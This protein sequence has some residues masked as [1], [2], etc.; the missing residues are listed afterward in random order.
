MEDIIDII[1]TETTNTIEITAQP[2]D[3]IIDVNIIDNRE[4]IVLNVTPT[5]VEININSL[6]GN[7]GVNWGD[8]EGTLSNQTDLQNTLNLKADLVDGKVPSSQLPSYVDDIVEVAT[9]SALPTTGET[10]KIYVVLDTNLIY[11]WSGSAY[12]EIKDSSAVW[13]AITG[14]LSSQTDLQSALNAKEP[15]ITAGTTLQ[16][17]R[18]DKSW[19]TLNTTIV[20]EGTN[21]Y[22]TDTRAR[23]AV[24]A[25]SPLAYNSGTGVFSIPAAT[26]S[27]NGYLTSTDWT[28]FNGKQAA[29]SGTGFVKISGTTISYDNTSYLPLTGGTLTGTLIG[30]RAEFT[31]STLVDGVLVNN[32]SGRG[33]RI[34]NA[35]AGYG[36]IINNETA[37]SAI[38]FVIQKSGLDKIYFTDSGAGNFTSSLTAS[39]F[40]KS[41]GTSSQYLMADGSVST[42]TNPVTGTGTSGIVAKFNGTS[43]ITDSIIYD[44]GT[45]VSIGANVTTSNKFTAVAST[46]SSYAVVAQASGAANGFWATLSGTGEIFR[47]QTSGGSYFIINNGGNAFLNG[48]LNVGDFASTSYKLNVV[49]TANFTGALSGTSA[50][51]SSSVVANNTSIFSNG[52]A[53]SAIFSNGGSAGNYNAIELRGGTAGTAVNWQI[54]KD[55]S[56]ANAFELAASTVAGGTTYGSPVFKITSTGAATFSSSV[57]ATSLF[58]NAGTGSNLRV[59]SGGTNILNV[60]NYSVADGFREFLLAGSEL[61]FYSGT[62]GGGSLSERMRITSAGNVGI[63]TT[64]PQTILSIETSGIQ[65]TVSPIITAQS[66][67][68]TYAGM[69]SIRDGAG[70]Q[71]GLIFQNYT[72]NVGLTEKMRI[73]SSGN[74]GIG[75]TAPSQNLHVASSGVSRI[76]IENTANAS[77]GAGIQMLVTSGGTA[78]G[79]GTIRTDNSDNMQFFNFGGERM[80]ITSDGNVII[81]NSVANDSGSKNLV[82]QGSRSATNTDI[83]SLYLAQIWNGTA[84]PVILSAQQD[85]SYGNAS[86]IFVLKTSYWNGSSV[87]TGE[88]LRVTATGNVGI[89]S[90][91]PGVKLQVNDAQT[92]GGTGVADFFNTSSSDSSPSITCTKAS[93][94]TSSS[95]RFIQFYANSQATAM[96]GIVGNGTSNV[97][98]ASLS[99]IRHKENINKLDSSLNKIMSLNPVSFNWKSNKEFVSAGFIA[100]EVEKVFPEYVVENMLEENGITYKGLTGGM[101]GGI[102]PVLVKAIQELKAELDTLKNK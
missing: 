75:T 45:R 60:A 99:D 61:S 59:I 15:T 70:D 96:G 58:V 24:S 13:G 80:R 79:N 19:Q 1:V 2:N 18:G 77:T 93:T 53:L 14:T 44:N 10:G 26:S 29:L 20:P 84:Y 102:V 52:S 55:N 73:T 21:L 57:T 101:T 46:T 89:G 56:T 34:I 36:L 71:R 38:P 72:A 76:L 8:I 3:E 40:V 98:F 95:A 25:S 67:G 17:W 47:G 5:V 9:Y 28:T 97:Q 92:G 35:G 12:I 49:G 27:Q 91:N 43:S 22:F 33:I 30:T 39:S 81:N 32:G 16:Y 4:D 100:Q 62:A 63:G 90:T 78:V 54:S 88:R 48:N 86:G 6:T 68:V 51:F 42:L 7:F 69:Y 85:T 64:S 74:V 11:R 23:A 87:V 37:S 94:T 65:S 50:N 83:S 82:V 31:T 66:S 41:G